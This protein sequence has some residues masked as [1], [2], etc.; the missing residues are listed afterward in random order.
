MARYYDVVIM[1]H[2]LSSL[3]R[4]FN[5]VDS[6]RA[7]KLGPFFVCAWHNFRETHEV[8][9]THS[10]L[11]RYIRICCCHDF[12]TTVRFDEQVTSI[13]EFS[14]SIT[15]DMSCFRWIMFLIL[16]SDAKCDRDITIPSTVD[17]TSTI[18]VYAWPSFC[19]IQY[20]LHTA[21]LRCKNVRGSWLWNAELTS[22]SHGWRSMKF[23]CGECPVLTSCS[24]ALLQNHH[25]DS[26]ASLRLL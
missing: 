14:V 21:W 9:L 19:M 1:L 22:T 16:N 8:A 4:W 11:H 5:G 20:F 18:V 26:R 7:H 6:L 17:D 2:E 10:Y 13:P 12:L 15:L 25:D 24:S 23:F 3:L